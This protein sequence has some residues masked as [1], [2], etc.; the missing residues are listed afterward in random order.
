MACPFLPYKL[1]PLLAP[2]SDLSHDMYSPQ[3]APWSTLSPP[4]FELGPYPSR[5]LLHF[6]LWCPFSRPPLEPG[7]LVP[8]LQFE[9]EARWSRPPFE[10]KYIVPRRSFNELRSLLRA[11]FE[12]KELENSSI[13]S[14]LCRSCLRFFQNHKTKRPSNEEV[15]VR[16]L[17]YHNETSNRS[18]TR[19]QGPK[20]LFFHGVQGVPLLSGIFCSRCARVDKR[21]L[22]ML[23]HSTEDSMLSGQS[24]TDNR[25]HHRQF[26]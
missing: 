20:S 21:C 18:Q 24:T 8:R 4:E 9:P 23:R 19:E 5:P 13:V 6:D 7:Y 3:F 17:T 16:S 22:R 12:L 26:E 10:P 14:P 11:L 15:A 2:D 25:I 1:S